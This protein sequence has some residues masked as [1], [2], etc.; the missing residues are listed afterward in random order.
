MNTQNKLE[1]QLRVILEAV[2]KM[3]LNFEAAMN[4]SEKDNRHFSQFTI[5]ELSKIAHDLR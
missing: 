1:I 3:P 2:T 5:D 4:C